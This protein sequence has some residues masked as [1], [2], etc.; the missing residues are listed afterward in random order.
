MHHLRMKMKI[1]E[2]NFKT[3]MVNHAKKASRRY[4]KH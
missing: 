3:V 4:G 2:F 1:R